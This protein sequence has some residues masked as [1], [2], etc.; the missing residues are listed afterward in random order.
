MQLLCRL[1]PPYNLLSEQAVNVD[2]VNEERQT[3]PGGTR[4]CILGI[5]KMRV[6]AQATS[7]NLPT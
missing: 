6:A 2:H 3:V 5:T 7:C 1:R 4:T